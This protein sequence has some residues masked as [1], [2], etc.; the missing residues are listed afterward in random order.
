[1]GSDMV[2]AL[3][4]ASANETTLLGVNYHAGPNQRHA[5]RISSGNHHESGDV[6]P[7]R[8]PV[9]QV[10]STYTAL[11]LQPRGE[12][13]FRFGVNEHR[14]SIGVTDWQSRLQNT[15]GGLSG[16]DLVRLALERAKSA[17]AATEIISDLIARHG[18][19]EDHIFLIADRDEAFLQETCGRYWAL[20]ECAQ[21]RVVTDAAM[22]R[23]DWSR[24]SPGLASHAIENSWWPDDGSKIDFV[25]CLG[26]T[27]ESTRFAQKRW[28]RASLM[29][30]QQH[31]AI[32]LHFLRHMLADHYRGC[33]NLF[34]DA[35]GTR[36][37]SSIMVDLHRSD[38]P[39]VVWIA[40]G[41]PRVSVYFP[42]CL[43]G[44]LPAALSA[45]TPAMATIEDRTHDF[46]RLVQTQEQVRLNQTLERLQTKFDQDAEDFCARAR[47]CQVQ[48]R[49]QSI[50]SLASEMMHQH[51]DAFEKEFCRIVGIP[52]R[53]KTK[54]PAVEEEL[55][56][57]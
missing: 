38:A 53:P 2:V 39:L 11:G 55:Y 15:Q 46:R 9:P 25:R 13:G 43:L 51:V 31:G 20:M 6:L 5:V 54:I 48:G 33:R 56:F 34:P 10:R 29:F 3:K 52:E 50:P 24:L 41:T 17:H 14:V 28:G 18:Q 30:T 47:E 32:D 22:I 44:E 19:Q 23:Q 37:A 49:P 36:L 12:W 42:V 35:K 40:F 21:S 45:D 26:E 27:T 57:A 4:G 7:L 1:M 8:E 16:T